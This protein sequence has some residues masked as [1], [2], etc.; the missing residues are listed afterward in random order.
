MRKLSFV[1]SPPL[2]DD[3]A[4]TDELAEADDWR[5]CWPIAFDLLHK[6]TQLF[7]LVEVFLR[8]RLAELAGLL[9]KSSHFSCLFF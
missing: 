6:F 8:A 3:E 2:D 7:L 9:S 5:R 1:I 4:D